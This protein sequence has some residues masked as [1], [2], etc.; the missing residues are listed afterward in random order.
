MLSAIMMMP[1]IDVYTCYAKTKLI[2][3][4][5]S[6]A[7]I[8]APQQFITLACNNASYQKIVANAF[9]KC[10]GQP[11]NPRAVLVGSTE[12]AEAR[13]ELESAL[14][15]PFPAAAPE[16]ISPSVPSPTPAKSDD[17]YQKI[18]KSAIPEGD[19]KNPLLAAAL[20]IASDCDIYEKK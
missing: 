16:P 5:G 1:R 11:L 10:C 17:G 6:R 14:S 20:K 13:A 2:F 19:L 4:G 15:A 7:I 8:T 12:E 3:A 18:D 9:Q